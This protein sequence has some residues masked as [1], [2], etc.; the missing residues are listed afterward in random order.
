MLGRLPYLLIK[1]TAFPSEEAVCIYKKLDQTLIW[2]FG[3]PFGTRSFK[4]HF[5][6]KKVKLREAGPTLPRP[7][8]KPATPLSLFFSAAPVGWEWGLAFRSSSAAAPV[9]LSILLLKI[10]AKQTVR[11]KYMFFL[12]SSWA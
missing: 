3:F 10:K 12:L 11:T 9:T 1:V 7:F 5:Q 4:S 8:N 2:L 6:K